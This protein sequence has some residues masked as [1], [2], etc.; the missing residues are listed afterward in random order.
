M[1]LAAR[2]SNREAGGGSERQSRGLRASR[3]YATDLRGKRQ[4]ARR[5]PRAALI[6]AGVRE[7]HWARNTAVAAATLRLSTAPLPGSTDAAEADS[8][9]GSP[10]QYR[11]R[12]DGKRETLFEGAELAA[13]AKYPQRL[14]YPLL[15]ARYPQCMGF[16]KAGR[17]QGLQQIPTKVMEAQHAFS[18]WIAVVF[19][20][21]LGLH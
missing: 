18:H 17:A 2:P 3:G 4:Y 14:W 6:H 13:R 10:S 16:G 19:R 21:T 1:I 9:F 8:D 5:P 15:V 11:G 20:R 12:G 7:L